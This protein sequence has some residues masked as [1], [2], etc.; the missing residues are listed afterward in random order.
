MSGLHMEDKED[1]IQP[2]FSQNS[3]IK[4]VCNFCDYNTSKK[5]NYNNHI[6]S[7]KH[8]RMTQDYNGGQ[9]SAK[10][11]PKFSQSINDVFICG[12]GKE[13]KHRQGL[14]K[15]RL[16]CSKNDANC[17]GPDQQK[18]TAQNKNNLDSIKKDDLVMML[19]KQNADLMELLK[20]GTNVTNNNTINNTNSHNKSFNLNFFLNETCKNAMNINE[21]VDSINLQINDLME[22]GK[23]GY[24]E[25]IS[26]IIVKNLNALDET[27]RPIH[28]TDKK[29]EIFYIKDEDKWEKEDT[30]KHKLKRVINKVSNQNIRLLPQYR[31][32]YPDYNNSESIHSDEH[33]NIVIEIMDTDIGKNEK[34]I[35]N[36]SNATTISKELSEN[37]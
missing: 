32:K 21:F 4:F 33:S 1:K 19:L 8:L 16:R 34:I 18:S 26:K 22:V 25:G 11:Q 23:I 27:I 15:H 10:I 30:Y 29:R 12:C 20:N 35:K 5:Y 14:W 17:C 7:A 36:I 28:C 13:Y 3:A 2:K 31:E 9:N 37:I 6:S 24:V